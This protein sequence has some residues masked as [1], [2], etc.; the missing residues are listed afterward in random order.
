MTVAA[1]ILKVLDEGPATRAQIVRGTGRK[2]STVDNELLALTYA[3]GLIERDGRTYRRRA[4]ATTA[5]PNARPARRL[6]F[7][8]HPAPKQLTYGASEHER[9]PVPAHVLGGW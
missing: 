5:A 2:P 6:P 8:V 4:P 1:E 3:R 7:V 9:A